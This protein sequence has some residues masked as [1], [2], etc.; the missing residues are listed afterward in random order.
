MSV[1]FERFAVSMLLGA[2]IGLEREQVGHGQLG[3]RTFC[4][5]AG[6]GTLGAMLAETT[7]SP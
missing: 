6:L 7:N 3:I 2:F 1:L 4:L 5:F